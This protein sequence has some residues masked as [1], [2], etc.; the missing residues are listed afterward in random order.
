VTKIVTIR[1]DWSGSDNFRH[2]GR[3][4][5]FR[6]FAGCTLQRIRTLS[7]NRFNDLSLARAEDSGTPT[8]PETRTMTQKI[9]RYAVTFGLSGCYMP[10]SH[11][12][13]HEFR[14]RAELA[15]FIRSELQVFDMPANLFGDVRIRR[16]W[17]FIQRYGSS[18]AHFRLCHGANELAFHGLTEDE[19]NAQQTED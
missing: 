13:A 14:T 8:K 7:S 19:F 17:G 16:L 12:G 10:D 15:D 11:E 1:R 9:A 5:G 2:S 4:V 3:L 18:T 6:R